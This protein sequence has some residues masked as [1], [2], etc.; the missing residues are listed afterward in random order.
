MTEFG[1]YLSN[2]EPSP[3]IEAASK[4]YESLTDNTM[5]LRKSY[6]KAG[7]SEGLDY[8][9][10]FNVAWKHRSKYDSPVDAFNCLLDNQNLFW[11]IVD[12]ALPYDPDG[13][14]GEYDMKR[15]EDNPP[16]LNDGVKLVE[17]YPEVASRII[18]NSEEFQESDQ[19]VLDFNHTVVN[20]WLVH[21]ANHAWDIWKEGFKYGN[22]MGELAYSRT[23]E[24]KGKDYGDYLFAFPI[25]EAPDP[26]HRGLKYGRAS[27]V[28]IGTGN[29]F[30][31]YGDEENQ[32]IFDR[33]EPTGCFIV[34]R[35]YLQMDEHYGNYWCVFGKDM[36]RPLYNSEEYSDC[37]KWIKNN[38]NTYRNQM[39]MWNQ[40]TPGRQVA[41]ER[42]FK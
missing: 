7:K 6:R 35:E 30:Y 31:H 2:L 34:D 39:R 29:V 15:D 8:T 13:V 24:T 25:D 36:H 42:R 18:Y 11:D 33:R 40:A 9:P 19:K 22:M 20:G 38:G 3:L 41:S 28:F 32:V 12:A 14:A 37:L 27:V 16:D 1:R 21:N 17:A 23:G 10:E 5:W 26:D 4:M